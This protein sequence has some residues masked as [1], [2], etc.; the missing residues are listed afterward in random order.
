MKKEKKVKAPKQVYR[1][2][3]HERLLTAEEEES[4]LNQTVIWGW[5]LHS[6]EKGRYIFIA[7]KK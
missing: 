1:V 3:Q 7:T 2:R 5:E 4:W 6:K